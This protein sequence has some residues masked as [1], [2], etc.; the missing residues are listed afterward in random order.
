MIKHFYS[1]HVEID[2]LIIE[3]ES[4]PIK[5]HEKKHLIALAESQ[6]H[7][8]ILDSILS[9]LEPQDKKLFLEHLNSK[10]HERIWKF[11]RSKVRDIEGKIELA[12]KEIKKE[13]YKDMEELKANK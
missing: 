3:V 11:L 6:I 8:A 13:L 1:Y 10:N 7:H 9:E 4:L 2:S 12:A 5:D